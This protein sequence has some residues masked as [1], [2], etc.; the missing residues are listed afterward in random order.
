[1]ITVHT[2]RELREHVRNARN[3]GRRIGFVP[4]M[5]NLHEGHISLIERSLAAD[6]FTVSSI[7]V[8]PLQFNDKS[9]LA[10]YPRTLPAD[11]E[12]LAAAGCDLLFAPD[13]DEMYPNGQ[14]AQSIVHV[15]VVSEG[16]CGGS[17][18]GHFD[19]VSTVVSKLFNQ[20]LPDMAFF[21]EKDFQQVAVIRKMVNDL[22]MPLEIVPVPTKRAA[23]GLALSSRNGY[24]SAEERALAPGLYQTLS[25]IADDFKAG[26]DL[27]DSLKNAEERLNQ[28]GFR[29]DY[30]EIRRTS[31]LAPATLNDHS[32][33]VLGAAFLGSARLID[34]L[35]VTL[36]QAND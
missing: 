11:Q 22:C 16:L 14:D 1:M 35:Q 21:G 25:E 34:N 33:V 2:I 12:K 17:R 29:T 15:P 13:V 5:G 7:F 10:R 30:L 27:S 3:S 23:D 31:D 28:R 26:K 6:C 8:N 18:P 9:D 19:G 32:V 24:L 20:V 36:N 4:T